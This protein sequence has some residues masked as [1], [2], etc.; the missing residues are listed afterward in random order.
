MGRRTSSLTVASLIAMTAAASLSACDTPDGPAG[1]DR[2]P[3]G[4]AAS[5]SPVDPLVAWS[6]RFCSLDGSL[7]TSMPPQPLE[8]VGTP[9]EADRESLLDYLD[10]VDSVLAAGSKAFAA[11][12]SAHVAAADRMLDRYRGEIS[13]SRTSVART[14]S[15][16]RRVSRSDLSLMF[17]VGPA[18]VTLLTADEIGVISSAVKASPALKAAFRRAAYCDTYAD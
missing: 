14:E 2:T 15:E 11:Y 18:Q 10:E 3:A 13:R 16:T 12:P 6:S 1:G 8:P 17:T 5:E 7:T 4:P 9:G